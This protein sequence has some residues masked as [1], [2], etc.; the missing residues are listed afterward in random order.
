M[1][2]LNS[3]FCGLFINISDIL[4]CAS[5]VF[6]WQGF[7][8]LLD[9]CPILLLLRCGLCHFQRIA[10]VITRSGSIFLVVLQRKISMYTTVLT[11]N[12]NQIILAGRR[13]SS[14]LKFLQLTVRLGICILF[15]LISW[16]I[17]STQINFYRP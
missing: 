9:C 17:Y 14:T 8:E 10:R 15:I 2:S 6:C 3:I 12:I 1:R 13:I 4:T 11:R 16:L 7:R 5:H